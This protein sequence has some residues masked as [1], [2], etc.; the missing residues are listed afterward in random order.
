MDLRQLQGIDKLVEPG[1]KVRVLN[2]KGQIVNHHNFDDPTP[3][4]HIEVRD[5]AL[6]II[7]D[8]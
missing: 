6:N 7:I 5:G 2:Q 4:D 8:R 1:V 3:I